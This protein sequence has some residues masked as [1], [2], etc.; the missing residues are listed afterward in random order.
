MDA[1]SGFLPVGRAKLRKTTNCWSK[2][3]RLR[4]KSER[5]STSVPTKR[6][7]LALRPQLRFIKFTF[8]ISD[9]H[10]FI[11][12]P[13]FGFVLSGPASMVALICS[14]IMASW[15]RMRRSILAIS[16]LKAFI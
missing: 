7:S 13:F 5:W 12:S 4:R 3:T 8:K 10:T 9:H 14:S 2:T 1:W 6:L 16:S 11:S 15:C